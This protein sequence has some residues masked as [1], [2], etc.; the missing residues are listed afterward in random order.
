MTFLLGCYSFRR[1]NLRFRKTIL[2]IVLSA[3]LFYFKAQIM[4]AGSIYLAPA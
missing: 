1:H 3:K 4:S 2:Q